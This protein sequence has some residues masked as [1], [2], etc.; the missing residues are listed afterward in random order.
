MSAPA[1]TF[2]TFAALAATELRL[3]LRRGENLLVTAV[4]PPAVLA[5]FASTALLPVPGPAVDTLLPGAI[6]L[7]VIAAAFVSLGIS[8]GYERSYGVLKR[9]GGAPIEPW[10][11]LAAKVAS[12]SVT[13]VLQVVLLVAVAV[14]AF[15]WSP[16]AGSVPIVAV[17]AL[18]LGIVAFGGLGLALA[19]ALRAE[20][21]LAV[22]NGAFMGLLLLGGIILPVDHL[23]DSLRTV[24]S[25]LPAAALV[26]AL[27]IGLGSGPAAQTDPA[28]SLVLLAA[29]AVAAAVLAASTFRW[30]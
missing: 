12:V 14:V 8:T 15:S 25:L 22:A 10:T 4:I 21:T 5:F 17:A 23:P 1:G 19:G 2:Q 6:A 29:W 18:V 24:A 13:V 28:G 3:A 20:A 16:G 26:E 9:L 11:V 30:E 7:G 27:G